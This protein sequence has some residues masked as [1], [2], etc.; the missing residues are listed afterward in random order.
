MELVV[1]DRRHRHRGAHAGKQRAQLCAL[2]DVLVYAPVYGSSVS[3]ELSPE[4]VDGEVALLILT[5]ETRAVQQVIGLPLRAWG[6]ISPSATGDELAAAI[7]ALSE[8]FILLDA[9]AAKKLIHISLEQTQGAEEDLL[10]P[11]T[12]RETEVLQLIAQGLANKQIASL[13]NISPHTVKYHISSIYNKLGA[14]NRTEA[15]RFGLRNGLVT[16]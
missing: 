16:L 2:V 15:V 1:G 13:L 5:E 10:E 4:Q 3:L 7:V 11:L 8:G 6:I 9:L 14:A 12:E